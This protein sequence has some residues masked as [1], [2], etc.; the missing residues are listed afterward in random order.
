MR[1]LH[2]IDNIKAGNLLSDYFLRLTTAQKEYADV[3]TIT[4]QGDFKKLLADFQPD[5]VH[6]HTCWE[7]KAATY[8][9]WAAKKHC[10]VV[11]SPHWALDEKARTTEQKSTKKVKTLLYQAKMVRGMDALLVTNEQERKEILQLGWTKRIDIVQDSVLNSSL[12]DDEMAQQTISF[13]RKVLDT[14]Y[15]FA[16]TAMEKDAVPSLLHVGLAQET[17]HNLLP[18]DQ[19]LN[20]RSLNP[21]QWRRIFLYADDEGIRE[22]VDNSISR[23]QLNAPTI[24]TAAIERFPLLLPKETTSVDTDKVIGNQPM[25]RQRLSDYSNKEDAI[26]KKIATIIANTRQIE[27]KKKLSL[28]LLADLYTVIKY[29]DYDED[30]LADVLRHLRLYRFS[31]RIIQLLAEKVLL[32][33]GFMPIPPRD[34]RKTKGIKR[35]N[36][37][38]RH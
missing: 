27:R 18:S 31:R 12:N 6:I 24:D 22:I 33:E 28:R 15:Q 29:N 4:Q 36:F 19:L 3:K 21:E 32:K 9:N 14:R 23:L 10:A 11:F 7:H 13:Y 8:A 16:M 35:N 38:Q 5:I 26:I 30:R 1:I 17:T 20:L 25:T 37:V 2:Y 34:D